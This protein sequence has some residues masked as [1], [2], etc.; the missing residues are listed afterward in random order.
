MTKLRSLMNKWP[1]VVSCIGAHA[2]PEDV[3][4]V[5]YYRRSECRLFEGLHRIGQLADGNLSQ[6]M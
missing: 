4:L 1:V 6:K 5:N 3:F 2:V